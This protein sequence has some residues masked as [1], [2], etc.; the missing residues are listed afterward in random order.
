MKHASARNVIE[1][2]FELLKAQWAILRSPAFYS[3]KVQNWIIMAC[4]LLHNYIRQEMVD[5]PIEQ[6]LTDEG[7]GDE[8]SGEYLGTVDSNSIWNTWRD[9]MDKS[10]YNEWRGI[11]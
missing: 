10:M 4:C 5:D 1:R 2:T 7:F 3:I 6:V 9:E 11:P 8:D